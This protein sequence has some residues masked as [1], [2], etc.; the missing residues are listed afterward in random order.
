MN[1]LDLIK[2]EHTEIL[3]LIEELEAIGD[4]FKSQRRREALQK[5]RNAF[6][7]LNRFER[8]IF[9]PALANQEGIGTMV[10]EA[11]KEL[12]DIDRV[13]LKMEENVGDWENNLSE[14]K[15]LTQDHFELDEKEL[16][17]KAEELL[18]KDRLEELGQRIQEMKQE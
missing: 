14:L 10:G 4:G 15:A 2:K 11:G 1:A 8:E 17:P 3:D 9:Y 18:G 16:F 13:L 7:L 12:R 6:D 5:I